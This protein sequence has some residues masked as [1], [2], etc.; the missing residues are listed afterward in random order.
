M[1][2][3]SPWVQHTWYKEVWY[4]DVNKVDKLVGLWLGA[5]T[6]HGGGDSFWILPKSCRSIVR[7][8]VW[9]VTVE[10]NQTLEVQSLSEELHAS[11]KSKIGD[12]QTDDDELNQELQDIFPEPDEDLY[13]EDDTKWRRRRLWTGGARRM[14]IQPKLLIIIWMLKLCCHEAE[15]T[16]RLPLSSKARMSMSYLRRL[17]GQTRFSTHESMWQGFTREDLARLWEH[18]TDWGAPEK[19]S[20]IICQCTCDNSDSSQAEPTQMFG[21]DQVSRHPRRFIGNTCFPMWTIFAEL[22]RSLKNSWYKLLVN[23][24]PP[25]RR[26]ASKRLTYILGQMWKN[27]M[28]RVPMTQRRPHGRCLWPRALNARS[29]M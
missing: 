19:R 11:V 21:W 15:K 4:R 28:L 27:S 8:T 24:W 13:L 29:Q 25:S 26:E 17:W 12:Y 6:C 23:V 20:M 16:W 18:C 9:S 2:D 7:S 10:E 1:P 14:N 5:T 22:R 3:I